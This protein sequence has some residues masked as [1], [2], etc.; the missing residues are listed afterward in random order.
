M[1]HR[2]G[3]K[4]LLLCALVACRAGDG[5]PEQLGGVEQHDMFYSCG[6]GADFCGAP[7]IGVPDQMIC[8]ADGAHYQCQR[9]GWHW[10]GDLGACTQS[11]DGESAFRCPDLGWSNACGEPQSG[12]QQQ[13][14]C[15]PYDDVYQCVRDAGDPPG[16]GHWELRRIGGCLDALGITCAAPPTAFYSCPGGSDFS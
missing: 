3:W 4:T 15:N 1:A 13:L 10:R 14:A 12:V 11:C 5:N 16:A 2:A 6:N 7:V 9:D 8:G